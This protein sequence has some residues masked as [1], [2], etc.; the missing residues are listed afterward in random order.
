MLPIA[1]HAKTGG[2]QRCCYNMLTLCMQCMCELQKK[3]LSIHATAGALAWYPALLLH[4]NSGWMPVLLISPL[5]LNRSTSMPVLPMAALTQNCLMGC[6]S[7]N[8]SHLSFNCRQAACESFS[9]WT[10]Q[11]ADNNLI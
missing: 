8:L 3:A 5:L 10:S 4:H 9:I 11:Y 7:D 1:V 6:C 2:W